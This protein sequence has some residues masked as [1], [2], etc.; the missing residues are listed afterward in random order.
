[1]ESDSLFLP[2]S[3]SLPLLARRTIVHYDEMG[4]ETR[5]DLVATEF[6]LTIY[7]N[8]QELATIVCSPQH[9]T[10]LV[11]GFLA[12]EGV[13]RSLDQIRRLT[14]HTHSGTARVE[15]NHTVNFNQEFYNKRYI[16]SC[17]GKTRQSFYF[18]ND[19][20]TA[21][22]VDDETVLS[23]QQVHRLIERMEVEAELFHETGGVHVAGL[24]SVEG[25]EEGVRIGGIGAADGHPFFLSRTDIGRHNALDKLYGYALRQQLS[26][27]GKV[28]TFSGRL[29]SEVVLKVAKL[30]VGIVL[31]R[32]AP[33]ALALDIADE[34]NITAV[35][36]VRNGSFNVYTHPRRIAKGL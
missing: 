30:G 7:V 19:A 20:H 25:G 16:A 10:D 26:L 14:V 28:L 29:S 9:M 8:G 12:S 13:I 1:M 11:V 23:P 3:R 18:Y 5:E 36:F 31:A 21:R 15:T 33:T 4:I 22:W 32:S 27:A 2:D 35:G 17:C 24:G 34:L 6:A